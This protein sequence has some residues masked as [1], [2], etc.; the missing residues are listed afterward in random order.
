M[1]E[2]LINIER[3]EDDDML[4]MACEWRQV[5]VAKLWIL[6]CLDTRKGHL[7]L[8][9]SPIAASICYLQIKKEAASE[10]SYT[11]IKLFRLRC[12]CWNCFP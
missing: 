1:I 12:R 7:K 5:Y 8:G 6:R 10:L 11:Y 3:K 9:L 2:T 4:A